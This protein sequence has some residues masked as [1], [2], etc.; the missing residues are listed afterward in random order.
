MLLKLYLIL[1]GLFIFIVTIPGAVKGCVPFELTVTSTWLSSV[2]EV[3]TLGELQK[4]LRE[5]GWKLEGSLLS[6]LAKGECDQTKPEEDPYFQIR[7]D[8]KYYVTSVRVTTPSECIMCGPLD[9]IHIEVGEADLDNSTVLWDSTKTT[10]TMVEY[11]L[12][13]SSEII[14]NCDAPVYGDSV[15]FT[16]ITG[17]LLEELML[18][19]L[20][21]SGYVECIVTSSPSITTTAVPSTSSSVVPT[22]SDMSLTSSPISSTAEISSTSSFVFE[23]T[24][25][26]T[27]LQSSSIPSSSIWS[28]SSEISTTVLSSSTITL[29]L[30]TTS[31]VFSSLTPDVTSS[32]PEMSS[33]LSSVISSSTPELGS[34]VSSSLSSFTLETITTSLSLSSTLTIEVSSSS[35]SVLPSS[36]PEMTSSP[37]VTSSSLSIFSTAVP[38]TISS[39]SSSFSSLSTGTSSPIQSSSFVAPSSTSSYVVSSSVSSFVAPS[40]TSSFVVPTSTSSSVAS[41]Y[42]SSSVSS[43]PAIASWISSRHS[44][45]SSLSASLLSVKASST[46][47]PTPSLQSSPIISSTSVPMFISSSS[48][49]PSTSSSEMF[50]FS[51]SIVPTWCP[52][53]CEQFQLIA[54]LTS[55]NKTTE[56]VAAEVEELLIEMT[57]DKKNTATSKGKLTSAIDDRSS[58][59]LVGIV[60][61]SF[62][63]AVFG[64]IVISDLPLFVRTI[65]RISKTIKARVDLFRAHQ[66]APSNVRRDPVVSL[67]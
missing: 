53:S 54:E 60:G 27:T 26:E 43:K 25:P 33:T 4:I 50:V 22:T 38:E 39:I 18:C 67:N 28:S 5:N 52:C 24:L 44:S 12:A 56:E 37:L 48:I 19:S 65:I 3:L 49:D 63:A 51:T 41:S 17:G 47:S 30:S 8:D 58:A 13:H 16:K 64:L 15:R 6:A 21:A 40:S 34:T 42:I 7:L 14:I 55:N 45:L 62:F 57:V 32:S 10:C 2:Y 29:V 59:K 9:D 23:T 35:S 66:V 1:A 11:E 20:A 61:A 36:T 46:F 31:S